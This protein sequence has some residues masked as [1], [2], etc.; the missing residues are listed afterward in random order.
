MAS[1]SGSVGKGGSNAEADVILVPLRL[2][3]HVAAL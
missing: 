2:N 3:V 1:I